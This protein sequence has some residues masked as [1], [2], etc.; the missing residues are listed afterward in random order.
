MLRL[1]AVCTLRIDIAGIWQGNLNFGDRYQQISFLCSIVVIMHVLCK[2]F[3]LN[4]S[5]VTYKFICGTVA[6]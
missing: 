2:K 1:L 3:T 5:S 4:I 6:T